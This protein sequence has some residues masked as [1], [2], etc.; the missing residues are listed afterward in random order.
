MLINPIAWSS[1]LRRDT[2]RI[3]WTRIVHPSGKNALSEIGSIFKTYKPTTDFKLQEA[4][5]EESILACITFISSSLIAN[6]A[7]PQSPQTSKCLLR[8]KN[9]LESQLTQTRAMIVGVAARP[10]ATKAHPLLCR[11]SHIRGHAFPLRRGQG[12]SRE[13]CLVACT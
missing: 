2:N 6:Q 8:L 3:P 9:S 10:V 7:C 12:M 13:G 1:D 11:R 5:S 4:C